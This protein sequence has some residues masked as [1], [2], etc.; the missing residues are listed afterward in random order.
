[1]AW[2]D[3]T[4]KMMRGITGS[5]SEASPASRFVE[6]MHVQAPHQNKDDLHHRIGIKPWEA[7]AGDHTHDGTTSRRIKFSDIEDGI[8]NL[9]GGRADSIYGGI[10]II[11][12][13]GI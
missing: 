10:P 3:E 9:D 7:A 8:F 13:G 11:D 12:G 4:D 6:W 1:M 2:S 5:T